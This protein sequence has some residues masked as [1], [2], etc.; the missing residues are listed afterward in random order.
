MR[1]NKNSRVHKYRTYLVYTGSTR[2]ALNLILLISPFAPICWHLV[3]TCSQAQATQVDH[4]YLMKRE[5]ETHD[6]FYQSLASV[7]TYSLLRG[8]RETQQRSALEDHEGHSS[9]S[10]FQLIFLL[11]LAWFLP[12]RRWNRTV[13]NF[14]RH[15]ISSWVLFGDA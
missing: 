13:T 8:L 14:P 5:I 15:T 10:L 11:P 7:E 9:W 3:V 6:V 4:K 2:S 1:L 12:L